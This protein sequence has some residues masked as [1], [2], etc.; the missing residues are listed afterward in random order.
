MTLLGRRP[1]TRGFKLLYRL[2]INSSGNYI[3]MRFLFL[4]V[5]GL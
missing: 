1:K 3:E 4:I 5:V 2:L